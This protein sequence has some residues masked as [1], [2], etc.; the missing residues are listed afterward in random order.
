VKTAPP[1]N[2][3]VERFFNLSLDMLCIA[4]VDGYFKRLNPAFERVLGWPTEELLRRPFVEFIHPDDVEATLRE[5]EKLASGIPTISFENRYRCADGSYKHLM[6]TAHPETESGLL[7]AVARDMTALKQAQE[8]FRVAVEL[9]P[10]AMVM[11]DGEGKIA[12]VN[13]ETERLFGYD[14]GELLGRSIE[15]LLP[16][17]SRSRHPSHRARFIGAPRARPMGAGRDL[18]ARRK[19]GAEFP[20]EIGLKPIQLAGEAFVLGTI[21]DLT[22]RKEGERKLRDT[23]AALR[24]SEASYRQLFEQATYG[25]YRSSIDGRFVTVNPA[26]VRML[27]Y[28]SAEELLA[29]DLARDVYANREDRNRLI[30][31][32]RTSGRF[33]E[34]EVEWHC[35]DGSAITVRL[36]GQALHDDAGTISGFEAIAEDVTERKVMEEQLR[37]AQKMEAVGQLTGGIAHD[38]N[39]LLTVILA[40]ADLVASSLEAHGQDEVSPDLGELRTAAERGAGMVRKLLAFSRKERIALSPLDLAEVV[41]EATMMLRRLLSESIEIESHHATSVG[42]VNGDSGAIEQILVNLATNAR[43][44]MPAGGTLTIALERVILDSG[45]R[46]HRGWGEPGEYVRLVVAD[47]GGGMDADTLRR[48]FEPFFTTKPVGEGTGLGMAM[49]YGLIKQHGAFVDVLSR[50]GQGTDV[51]MYFPLVVVAERKKPKD[52]PLGDLPRGTETILLVEDEAPI[53]RTTQ[54]ILE[55]FGYS[56]LGAGDGEEALDVYRA[57]EAEIDLV[58]SDVVMPKLTGPRF[59]D[60]LRAEGKEVNILFA[61][62]YTANELQDSMDVDPDAPL[63]HKP[64]TAQELL[65]TV[66]DALDRAPCP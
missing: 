47:T 9:S 28:G 40:N 21:I 51:I 42:L 31:Q 45:F 66:R 16:L 33:D 59:R 39:N 63:L 26:L 5:V 55:R 23:A 25:I 48:V 56:V 12:L 38:L 17:H 37:Q 36:A 10:S 57:H 61:S 2:Y 58:I 7:Y 22:T 52:V 14:R 24:R 20:V 53:R 41:S 27:R 50:P 3:L 43:D 34:L 29:V 49:V 60:V 32:V 62:G 54:R 46:K 30:E 1:Q 6:W 35:K 11:V 8:R 13:E 44:A 64:W 19:D 65:V 15:M 18:S 4:G